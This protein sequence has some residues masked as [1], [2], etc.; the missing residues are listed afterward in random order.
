MNYDLC[1]LLVHVELNVVN[2]GNGRPVVSHYSGK[3]GPD[4]RLTETWESDKSACHTGQRE[5]L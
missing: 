4:L 5:Y 2:A 1:F 3:D